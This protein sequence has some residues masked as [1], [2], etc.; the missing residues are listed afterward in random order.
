MIHPHTCIMIHVLLLP[1]SFSSTPT[2]VPL[3]LQWQNHM[4]WSTS[5][6]SRIC[7]THVSHMLRT[8]AHEHRF[9]LFRHAFVPTR[10]HS[11]IR[12]PDSRRAVSRIVWLKGLSGR[13]ARAPQAIVRRCARDS[14]LAE[15]RCPALWKP[16]DATRNEMDSPAS[17]WSRQEE[18]GFNGA[19]WSLIEFI[20]YTMVYSILPRY[21]MEQRVREGRV[22]RADTS[23]PLLLYSSSIEYQ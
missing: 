23:V 13:P 4:I 3:V 14:S 7:Y 12:P 19:K 8:H 18:E 21:Y 6:E 17:E 1:P 15:H 2:L 20:Y 16:L 11:V 22:L 10:K 9:A 5:Q